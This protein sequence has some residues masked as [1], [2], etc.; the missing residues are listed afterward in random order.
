MS[1]VLGKRSS[2]DA[3]DGAPPSKAPNNNPPAADEVEDV[4]AQLPVWVMLVLALTQ[5]VYA[6]SRQT[7]NQLSVVMSLDNPNEHGIAQESIVRECA[8]GM[9]AMVTSTL[10]ILS[11]TL[12]ARYGAIVD[13]M[14]DATESQRRAWTLAHSAVSDA[15]DRLGVLVR[16]YNAICDVRFSALDQEVEDELLYAIGRELS[17]IS[18]MATHLVTRISE[19]LPANCANYLQE[20]VLEMSSTYAW[21]TVHHP[22]MY[23]YVIHRLREEMRDPDAPDARAPI[24]PDYAVTP[25]DY[26][27]AEALEVIEQEIMRNM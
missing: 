15:M 17:L 19:D 21:E 14:P 12:R 10:A 18:R 1:S 4:R 3:E 16:A 27:E 11:G 24:L 23:V 5:S 2:D 8:F 9:R 25:T 6:A 7:V 13:R 26:A 20:R 22:T